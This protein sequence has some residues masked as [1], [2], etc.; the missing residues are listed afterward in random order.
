MKSILSLFVLTWVV[1]TAATACADEVAYPVFPLQQ[2]PAMNG[3]WNGAAWANIPEA[4]G[5]LS[6]K[7]GGLISTRQTSFKMGWYGSNLYL[8]V[9]CEEPDPGKVVFDLKKYQD[10]YYP[11]DN[12][13]FLFSR[14]KSPK[15]VKQF[16]TNSRGARWTNFASPTAG[17]AWQSSSD[18]GAD[19]WCVEVKIPFSQLGIR[20]D[21]KTTPFW[22]NLARNSSGNEDNEKA[23]SYAPVKNAFADVDHFVSLTFQDAPAPEQLAKAR[24]SLNRLENW[25]RDRLWKIANVRE[26]FLAEK[27][28]EDQELPFLALKKEAKKMLETKDLT[29]AMALIKEYD[30]QVGEINRPTKSLWRCDQSGTACSNQSGTA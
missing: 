21:F 23:S 15:S 30:Q 28:D 2:A 11:D 14:D 8:A 25:K 10:G 5:F 12:L 7:T 26:S 3:E 6:T 20:A 9:K 18:R 27:L 19:S 13:E 24:K 4:A 22:F 16:V 29:G 1:M 17:D